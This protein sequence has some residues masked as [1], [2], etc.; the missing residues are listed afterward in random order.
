MVHKSCRIEPRTQLKI[1]DQQSDWN[2][3][4]KMEDDINDFLKQEFE[5]PKNPIVCNQTNKT[6]ISIAT[7]RGSWALLGE[8]YTNT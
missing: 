7:D 5:D 6:L 8:A 1:Q 2:T 4:K 3:K